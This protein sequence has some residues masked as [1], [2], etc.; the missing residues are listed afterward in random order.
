MGDRSFD[1]LYRSGA[2]G[3]PP[4]TACECGDTF[5]THDPMKEEPDVNGTLRFFY[6]CTRAGCGCTGFKRPPHSKGGH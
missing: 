4:T 2:I 5:S 6:P 1:A 3:A